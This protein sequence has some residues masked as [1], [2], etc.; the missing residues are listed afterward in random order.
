MLMLTDKYNLENGLF[1]HTCFCNNQRYAKNMLVSLFLFFK[2]F[3]NPI[4][5]FSDLSLLKNLYVVSFFGELLPNSLCV[6]GLLAIILGDLGEAIVGL[7][8]FSLVMLLPPG[9]FYTFL[10]IQCILSFLRLCET[11]FSITD[12]GVSSFTMAVWKASV[13]LNT[14]VASSIRSYKSLIL[15]S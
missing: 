10:P 12:G 13:F 8:F 14:K 9:P 2:V 11:S 5:S 15:S 7:A 1:I 3:S 4:F 6:V